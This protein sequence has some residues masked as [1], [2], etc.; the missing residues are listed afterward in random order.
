MSNHGKAWKQ[1]VAAELKRVGKGGII[2]PDLARERLEDEGRE[3]V[4][5]HLDEAAKIL[6]VKRELMTALLVAEVRARGEPLDVKVE[7]LGILADQ[8]T[9]KL[10]REKWELFR[11]VFGHLDVRDAP[12]HMRWAAHQV[13]VEL[14][15]RAEPPLAEPPQLVEE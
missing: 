12:A 1:A 13:G 4:Q 10:Q 11:D 2:L 7:T 8:V 5:P 14:P 15:S 6:N 3:T 9:A